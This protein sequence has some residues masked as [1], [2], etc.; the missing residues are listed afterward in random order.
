MK[1][2]A[3]DAA[4]QEGLA[5]GTDDEVAGMA[6]RLA[7]EVLLTSRSPVVAVEMIN[8][9]FAIGYEGKTRIE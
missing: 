7:L 6:I 9:S 1:G 8:A 3:D 5:S 2:S 4:D